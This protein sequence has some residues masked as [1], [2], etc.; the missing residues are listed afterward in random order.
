MILKIKERELTCGKTSYIMGI[1]NVTPDSFSDGGDFFDPKSAVSHALQMISD[2]ADIIDIGGESTRPGADELSCDEEIS[3]VVPVISQL[4]VT[5]PNCIISIDTRKAKV[6]RAAINAGADIINDI[7]GLQFS[8]EI[9]QVAA[10]TGA[11]L[12]LMHMR[13]TP[14]TMQNN[15]NLI[16]KNIVQDIISFL[17]EAIE[18]ACSV[19]VSKYQIAIDPGLGFSKNQDQNISILNRI[20]EFKSMNVPILVGHSRKSFIGKVLNESDPSQRIWG[21]AGVTAYLA[22]NKIDILRVHDVKE[23][24]D[25]VKLTYACSNNQL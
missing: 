16:Y 5:A 17:E 11:G 7:S 9:A 14:E 10:D 8:K 21:T 24:N 4:R 2:G 13:G 20:N 22:M 3:R 25:V 15:D 6:A 1:L 19:G 12:I 23:M 18:Y